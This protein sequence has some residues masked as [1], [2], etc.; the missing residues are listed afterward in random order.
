[1]SSISPNSDPG[2]VEVFYGPHKLVP[3]PLVEF[4]VEPQFNGAGVRQSVVTSLTLTGSILILPSGS[5]EQ[6]YV[7]QDWLKNTVFGTDQEDFLILAGA[8]NKTLPSGSIICSGL[9]PRVL[10]INIDPDIHVTRFD[11]TVELEDTTNASGVSGVTSSLSN[12]WSFS[13]DPESCT[14]EITHNVSATGPDGEPDKFIQAVRAVK[15]LIGIE[16]LPI[17]IPCFAQPN[18]SGL[19]NAIH[20]SNPA[21]GPIFEYSHQRQESA[22][23]ANG[24]YSVTETFQVV[25]GVPFYYSSRSESYDENENGVSTIT[26]QGTIQ[27]LGRTLDTSFGSPGGRAFDR[28]CSGFLNNIKP[29]L[30]SDASGVYTKYKQGVHPSGLNVNNPT[31]FTITQNKCAGTVDFS[32]TYTDDPAY[33][34][35][36][37]IIS[38]SCSINRTDGIRLF[39][40]HPI[41]FRNLG[42]LIQDIKTTTPGQITINCQAQAKNTGNKTSDINRAIGFVESE[43]N[44]LRAIHAN[45]AD[46]TTLKVAG[47]QQNI[48]DVNLASSVT[49]TYEFTTNLASTQSATTDIVLK[50]V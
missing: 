36:S 26:L 16:N 13:E 35:P 47:L 4:N 11:Y 14:L 42:N 1:M 33:F 7:K 34:L 23:V 40:S 21:G 17:D 37:G 31:S 38:K 15:E 29:L 12:Q 28:A 3:A 22:D 27:G 41:P 20:P 46:F 44:R 49:V 6:M 9:T 45:S 10:S 50:T 25:S 19:F 18:F 32:V 5:Y 2:T 39:A 48:D 30:P 24:T 8:L 43:L